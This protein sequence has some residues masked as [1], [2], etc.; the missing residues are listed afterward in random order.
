MARS[1]EDAMNIR[2]LGLAVADV[3]PERR[4][5][6]LGQVTDLFVLHAATYSAGEIELFDDVIARLAAEI[7]LE[8]RILLAQRLAKV[9]NAPGNVM[10]MLAFDD[11]IDVAGPVLTH[12]ERL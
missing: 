1:A 12:S 7:E 3:A 5:H 4:A 11:S 6:V 9:P 2:D 8:A 10:R